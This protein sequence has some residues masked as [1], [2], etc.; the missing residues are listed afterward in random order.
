M[1]FIFSANITEPPSKQLL[2]TVLRQY[3]SH[4]I[5]SLAQMGLSRQRGGGGEFI[6]V[7]GTVQS[8]SLHLSLFPPT[9]K[10][11]ISTSFHRE[12]PP[13][14]PLKKQASNPLLSGTHPFFSSYHRCTYVLVPARIPRIHDLSP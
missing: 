12:G 1:A 7:T 2:C 14:P 8:R 4:L 10:R 9:P 11:R 6:F 13:T 3:V 5:S